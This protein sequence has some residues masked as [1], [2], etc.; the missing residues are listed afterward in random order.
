M[1]RKLH[2]LSVLNSALY[3]HFQFEWLNC[4]EIRN[5][6]CIRFVVASESWLR[7]SQRVLVTAKPASLGYGEASESW[8]R[9]QNLHEWFVFRGNV[10]H[11]ENSLPV[12]LLCLTHFRGLPEIQIKLWIKHQL[13]K[14]LRQHA[15]GQTIRLRH[16]YKGL[17]DNMN[18]SV[19]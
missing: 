8:L 10:I 15:D 17:T 3:L 5:T 4:R 1:A 19:K 11:K 18:L 7:R 12:K 9:R 14:L 6:T 13:V 16:S 2:G